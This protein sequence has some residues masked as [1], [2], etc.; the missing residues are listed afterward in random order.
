MNQGLP[1]K[2]ITTLQMDEQVRIIAVFVDKA[3]NNILISMSCSEP[4]CNLERWTITDTWEIV[5]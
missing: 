3:I 5:I 2:K 4:E 1:F